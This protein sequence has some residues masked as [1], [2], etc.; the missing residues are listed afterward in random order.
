MGFYSEDQAPGLTMRTRRTSPSRRARHLALELR[1]ITGQFGEHLRQQGYA[2]LTI[3]WYQGCLRRAATRRAAQGLD[4][5]G[6]RGAELP[7]LFRFLTRNRSRFHAL[8]MHRAALHAW[9]RFRGIELDRRPCTAGW[10]PW[11]VEYDRFLA[12][13]QG[14][15][16]ST[17]VYRKRYARLFL[18]WFFKNRDANWAKVRPQA[19][20]RFAEQAIRG[21]KPS[22]ANVLL[23]SIRALL[24]FAHW[25]GDIAAHLLTATPHVANYGQT[26]QAV[27]LSEAQRRRLLRA[28]PP[29]DPQSRRDRAMTLCMVDLGLRASEVA[30]LKLVDFDLK[31]R[32]LTVFSPKTDAQRVLPLT[33]RL[34]AA[35]YAYLQ[36]G[37][38]GRDSEQLFLRARPPMSVTPT[39]SFVRG[40]IRRAYT[41]CL[42]PPGWTGTHR[43]RHT[44]ATRLFQRG[45]DLKQIADLLGHHVLTSTTHYAQTDQHGLR[46]LAQPWPLR[47]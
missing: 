5:A 33:P 7:D 42:F 40:A 15:S 13:S 8:K 45:V 27:A 28:F 25:H 18:R 14:L 21:L 4:L 29:D 26:T 9:L 2:A 22:S 16:A 31:Q 44:F 46:A 20:W 37:R 43:L 47:S 3:G 19:L 17:R 24:R 34:A 36:H 6:L 23:C 30:A 35:I 38:P 39:P 10:R 1:I 11:L 12:S 41:R 32:R